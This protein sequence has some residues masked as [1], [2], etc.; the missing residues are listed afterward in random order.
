MGGEHLE[1]A[2]R[3]LNVHG[4]IAL[5]GAISPYNATE[6]PPGPRNLGLIINKRLTMRGFIVRDHVDRTDIIAEVGGW[7]RDG[8]L[9]HPE[10]VVEG[11]DHAPEAFL[12]LL[13]GANTG[14][15]VVRL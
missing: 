10:T 14:K 5:C 11:I 2:L 3:H 12:D 1:A 7:L 9:Q 4:R 13:R 15:M 8:K 6:P